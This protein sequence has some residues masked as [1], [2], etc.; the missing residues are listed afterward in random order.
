MFAPLI[1]YL[2]DFL[3]A[4]LGRRAIRLEI[5]ERAQNAFV[6]PIRDRSLFRT[7][8]LVLEVSARRPLTEIQHRGG[9]Q[10]EEA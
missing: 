8:T 1:R 10:P 6:S 9:F 3:S 7:A 2:Q 5:I 4:R